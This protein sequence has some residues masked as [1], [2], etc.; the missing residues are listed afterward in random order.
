M[1][2]EID[3]GKV[4]GKVEWEVAAGR[5]DVFAHIYEGGI[6][7]VPR[8]EDGDGASAVIKVWERDEVKRDLFEEIAR[9]G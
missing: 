6:P 3:L 5:G 9:N 7:Y 8:G 1:L 4:V 2:I